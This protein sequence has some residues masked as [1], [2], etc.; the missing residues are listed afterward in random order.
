M[1]K[2]AIL[3]SVL[4]VLFSVQLHAQTTG[5]L[6]G[7]VKDNNGEPVSAA[8]VVLQ[9]DGEATPYG[10]KTDED[11]EFIIIN[12]P[13]GLYDLVV[14]RSGF[15][16]SLYEGLEI[17]VNQTTQQTVRLRPGNNTLDVV[18]FTVKNTKIKKDK[19]GTEK[20][21]NVDSIEDLAVS[22][23]SD[24]I[25]LQAGVTNVGGEI[26]VRGSRSNEVNF[27]I[28]GMSVSDPVDGGS[29]LEVDT[30]AIADMKIYTGAFTAEYGNAQSGIV[31]IVTKSGSA[32][33]GGKVEFK[34]DH[35]VNDGRNNDQI[36]FAIGGPVLAGLALNEKFTFFVNGAGSWADG[37]YAE[38]YESN[39]NDDFMFN[40]VSLIN[41]IYPTYDAYSSR[42][43]LAG[44][45]MGTRNSNSYNLNFKTKYVINKNANL[46]FAVRGDR[47]VGDSF[48]WGWKYALDHFIEYETEQRQYVVTYDQNLS[49]KAN[50]KL[51]ASY[52]KKSSYSGPKGITRD[53]YLVQ[54]VTSGELLADTTAFNH[55]VSDIN[56]F[57]SAL[58]DHP[59][60]V[61]VDSDHDGVYDLGSAF[62]PSSDWVYDTQASSNDQPVPGYSAP[63]SIWS[64][65]VDDETS[66]FTIR[67]DLQWAANKI[68]T[69]KTGFELIQYDIK[70]NQLSNILTVYNDRRVAYL[71]SIFDQDDIAEGS[72]S[73][74]LEALAA[75]TEGLLTV[76]E[77]GDE[78]NPFLAIYTPEAYYEAAKASSGSR[79]GYKA[80]PIQGAYYAQNKMEWEGMIVNAGL[81]FDFWYIGEDYEVLEDSGEYR[82]YKFEDDEKF[83]M[84]VSP[85]VGVS[86]PISDRDVL[87]FAY[88]YQNQLPPMKYIFT[89]KTPEDA[90]TAD[91]VISVGNAELEPQVT[92]TYEV[93]LQHLINEDWVLDLSIY[94][95]NYYNYVSTRKVSDP[96]EQQVSWYEFISEDYASSK[97]IDLALDKSL[98]NFWSANISY[99][100]AWAEGNNS[101]T[102]IQDENTNL[103][104]FPL[105]W[106]IRNNLS[107]NLVFR[108]DRGEE[109]FIPFT[110]AILPLDDLSASMT[111]TYASGKPYTPQ[112][113]ETDSFL[114]PN[115]ERMDATQQ[116]NIKI[117]KNIRLGSKNSL[118]IYMDIA[119]IFKNINV[120][121]VY[122]KTG[123]PYD[124]GT[125]YSVNGT[126]FPETSFVNDQFIRDPGRVS[127]DRTITLGMS[128]NF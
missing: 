7:Q 101:D 104:E 56:N 13:P 103:R 42:D 69:A 90:Q 61:S 50:L 3:I 96:D 111:Y 71:N 128:Y 81:R 84:M 59:G 66:S 44:F 53:N 27:S 97:G 108:I 8:N 68:N 114:D 116:T 34:S 119:N 30:D 32:E 16:K 25:A 99:S 46:T 23:V 17:N 87:R 112:D 118:R 127:K 6:K 31:N 102:I 89:S 123:E 120:D 117:T 86:H 115:S 74:D 2:T 20:T 22:D 73:D 19:M 14:S 100:L 43:E 28:D 76:L 72:T 125:D 40:G 24:L 1:R 21:I 82:T 93:G 15:Q 35:L 55:Y 95:K 60:Y 38:Y 88:N 63:G 45:D 33:Y 51:K 105:D 62:K 11:G 121:E 109:F 37:F 29:A 122:P 80:T 58:Y 36:K 107:L 10:N 52:F 9:L 94:Y 75:S 65:F 18:K 64:S 77:T 106:D 49:Q 78:E 26:R 54:V 67:G 48:A 12:I 70:K 83:Q 5:M 41:T 39:A 85:R 98:S 91:Q 4:L 57:G 124:T 79:D 110:N 47:S 92:I 126:L 113:P